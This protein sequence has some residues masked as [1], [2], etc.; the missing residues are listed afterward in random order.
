VREVTLPHHVVD[1]QGR[2]LSR[3]YPGDLPPNASRSLIMFAEGGLQIR[4]IFLEASCILQPARW[5]N[6]T[7]D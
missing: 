1:M 3:A 4:R 7:P 5:P 2:P 6:S